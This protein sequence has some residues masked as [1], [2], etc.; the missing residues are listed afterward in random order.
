MEYNNPFYFK[1][2]ILKNGRIIFGE[3]KQTNNYKLYFVGVKY[4]TYFTNNKVK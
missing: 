2:L 3:Q 4:F 1:K